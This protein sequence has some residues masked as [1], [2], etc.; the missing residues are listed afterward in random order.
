MFF[1][2][3]AYVTGHILFDLVIIGNKILSKQ[4][5]FWDIV[6]S[7]IKKSDMQ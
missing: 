2:Q 1:P 6:T 7:S 5:L 4:Q 3:S